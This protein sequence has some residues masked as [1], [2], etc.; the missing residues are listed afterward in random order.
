MCSTIVGAA[1]NKLNNSVGAVI[2]KIPISYPFPAED[3]DVCSLASDDSS[4]CPINNGDSFTEKVSFSGPAIRP[5]VS[6]A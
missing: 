6:Y 1:I 3:V 2:N 5:P 4:K